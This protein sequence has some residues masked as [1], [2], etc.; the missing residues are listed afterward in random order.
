[1]LLLSWGVVVAAELRCP[2]VTMVMD[3]R[4]ARSLCRTVSAVL[5]RVGVEERVYTPSRLTSWHRALKRLPP[6]VTS[7]ANAKVSH[8]PALTRMMN[9]VT[10]AIG[11]PCCPG[12]QRSSLPKSAYRLNND[13]ASLSNITRSVLCI[14]IGCLIRTQLNIFDL[15]N[16]SLLDDLG[17]FF[18]PNLRIQ[19]Q[20]SWEV[21]TGL[22][23]THFLQLLWLAE[24]IQ[25]TLISET[26]R[27][28]EVVPGNC[29]EKGRHFQ[30]IPGRWLD[31]PLVH[32]KLTSIRSTN[33]RSQSEEW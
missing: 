6:A 24:M 10:T 8:R 4:L 1:M 22:M 19:T 18:L 11:I 23:Q 33:Q 21:K 32:H 7:H 30:N 2:A 26:H 14:A 5:S 13:R 28:E 17:D 20:N 3:M 27:R 29:W 9:S 15:H 12:L 16:R 31:E 25:N